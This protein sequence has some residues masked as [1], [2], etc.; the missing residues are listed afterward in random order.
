MKINAFF[1]SFSNLQLLQNLKQTTLK[2]RK[3]SREKK[4]AGNRG[5]TSWAGGWGGVI[6]KRYRICNKVSRKTISSR[7][8][9]GPSK[10]T[11]AS[12]MVIK[13]PFSHHAVRKGLEES[14]TIR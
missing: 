9:G 12:C 2:I 3:R 5:R 10:S 13:S 11:N 14:G 7:P 8:G 4:Q 1:E 6:L